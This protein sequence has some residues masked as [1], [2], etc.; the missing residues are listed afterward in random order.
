MNNTP[1]LR[2]A[3]PLTPRNQ[4]E[5]LNEQREDSATPR[6]KGSNTGV[7]M[8]REEESRPLIP[9]SIL[10][11][12][13]QRLYV[14]AFYVGLTAWRFYDYYAL[15][16]DDIS[17]VTLFSKW[18]MID[19]IFLFGLPELRI[20]WLEWSATTITVVYGLH[21]VANAFLMF[22]LPV[23]CTALIRLHLY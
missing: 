14:S 21:A 19:A 7:S 12:P 1:R 9:F 11:A 10:D 4:N 16:S 6:N 17:S 18:I 23:R 3:Y 8:R 2:S 22:R 15:L 20:P 13:T 5:R